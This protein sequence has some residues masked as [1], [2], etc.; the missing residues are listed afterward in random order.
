MNSVRQ[1]CRPGCRN[2]A[3]ATLTFDYRQSIAVLGPL[4]TTS[5]PHSWDLCEFHATRMTAPRGW[6]MLRNLPAYSAASVGTAALDDDLTALADTVHE[7]AV[8]EHGRPA[9]EPA[10]TPLRSLPPIGAMRP[11][12][13][14]L[15]G[16]Q[17]TPSSKPAGSGPKHAAPS[18]R[19]GHLRVLPDP[20]D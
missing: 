16:P 8:R 11:V 18:G 17:A 4:G 20:V 2:H 3:V 13:D 12:H 14:G 1:C 7:R 6:E 5:E 19:R 10:D 15:G 9:S